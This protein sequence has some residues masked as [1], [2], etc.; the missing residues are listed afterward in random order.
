MKIQP[1]AGRLR[2]PL[3]GAERGIVRIPALQ[4]GNQLLGN[5]H[6]LRHLLLGKSDRLPQL[7]DPQ[8]DCESIPVVLNGF[9]NGLILELSIEI[10]LE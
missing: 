6:A 4:A 5:S 7:L 8:S 2:D 3:Q 9:P 10:T 1:V